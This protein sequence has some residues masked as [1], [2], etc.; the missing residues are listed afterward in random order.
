MK[1]NRRTIRL[2]FVYAVYIILLSQLQVTLPD[3]FLILG[4]R[5]DLTRVLVIACGYLF[6]R[7]DGII[8]GL[9]A[10]FM[11]DLFAGRTLGLGM[12]LLMYIGLLAGT[13]L[14]GRFRL[15]LFIGLLQVIWLTV[16]YELVIT[17][18]VYLAPMLPDVVHDAGLLFRLTAATL[19]GQLLANLIVAVPLDLLLWLVG[20]Y[21]R[22]KQLEDDEDSEKTQGDALWPIR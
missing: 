18:I 16:A 9:A 6:G 2:L 4:S 12:L 21:R 7:Q 17:V 22:S 1:S 15:N 13:A 10:G 19:P 5:P 14:R 11:R 20:P 8:A 3:R